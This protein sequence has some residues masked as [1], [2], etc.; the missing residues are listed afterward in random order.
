MTGCRVVATTSSSSQALRATISG[1]PSWRRPLKPNLHCSERRLSRPD[2]ESSWAE[3]NRQ[4]L[5]LCQAQRELSRHLQ[6]QSARC[7]LR[8]DGHP[9]APNCAAGPDFVT[10]TAFWERDRER[11]ISRFCKTAKEAAALPQGSCRQGGCLSS[12]NPHPKSK[13]PPL[14][15]SRQN[16]MPMPG[17]RSCST[18]CASVPA[19]A[20]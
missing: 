20:V 13:P 4:C 6:W 18:R 2:Q 17:P 15:G 7:P 14:F 8:S 19:P 11:A 10:G 3:V 12:G 1:W 16:P 5:Q 9:H